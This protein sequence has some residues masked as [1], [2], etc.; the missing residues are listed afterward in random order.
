MSRFI[1]QAEMTA[2]EILECSYQVQGIISTCAM[3]LDAYED[4]PTTANARTVGD[5]ARALRAA[6][7]LL[8]PVHDT[9][10]AHEGMAGKS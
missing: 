5:V 1:P 10:E 7:D 9:L 6:L 4:T 3:A 2:V 8:G